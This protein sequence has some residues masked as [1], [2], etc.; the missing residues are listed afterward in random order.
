M[1][2]TSRVR[3]GFTLIEFLVVIAIIAVLIGLL[4][5][6]VQKVRDAAYKA[7]CQNHLK[8]LGLAL[9]GYHD[10][11][12]AFPPGLASSGSNVSDAEATGLTV[13]LP[14]LEQDAAF[15]RYQFAQPWWDAANFE[16]VAV[17]VKVFFCPANRDGGSMDLGPVSVQWGFPLPPRA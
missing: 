17:E 9:T 1:S 8:Q 3:R 2:T 11:H 16:A 7:K 10:G 12:G 13:L 5:P 4:L 6:A 15:Q 14:Y